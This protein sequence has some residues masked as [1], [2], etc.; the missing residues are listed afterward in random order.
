MGKSV[1]VGHLL[2]SV[3][4]ARLCVAQVTMSRLE[5]EEIVFVVTQALGLAL[6]EADKASGY[7]A[8]ENFLHEEARAGRRCVP[9]VDEAQNLSIEALEEL[10]M[11]SNFQLGSQPL[12]QILL[13][14]QPDFAATLL[15]DPALE[16]L[17]Q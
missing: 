11:L 4:P 5:S 8:I 15:D 12:L 16:Q 13:L 6:E 7:G 2:G 17:R 3:D 10:R 1:L 9:V 14:G